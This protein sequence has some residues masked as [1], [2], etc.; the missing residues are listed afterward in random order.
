[1][2]PPPLDGQARG[3]SSSF[4]PRVVSFVFKQAL[5]FVFL[6]AH[7]EA[8]SKTETK[9]ADPSFLSARGIASPVTCY[10]PDGFGFRVCG[11]A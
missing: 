8:A 10:A 1:M 6:A 5:F 2:I 3:W 11:V 4:H 7:R 9:P